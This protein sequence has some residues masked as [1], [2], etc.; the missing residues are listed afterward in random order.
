MSG[1]TNRA[2]TG[3]NASPAVRRPYSPG[4]RG[5]GAILHQP[6]IVVLGST[7]RTWDVSIGVNFGLVR[8]VGF[9]AIILAYEE[10]AEGI[11]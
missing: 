2:R 11:T 3:K 10:L 4:S 6:I 5:V 1:E 9:V 8:V 7:V